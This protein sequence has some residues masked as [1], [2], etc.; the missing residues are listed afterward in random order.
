MG[1]L[2]QP[3][4][5]GGSAFRCVQHF[6]LPMVSLVIITLKNKWASPDLHHPD[7]RQYRLNRQEENQR[8][9]NQKEGSQKEENQKEENQKEENQREENPHHLSPQ[10]VLGPS[11]EVVQMEWV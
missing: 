6:Y 4:A 7:L 3:S 1:R 10:E 8:E 2:W 9:E 5:M 11:V